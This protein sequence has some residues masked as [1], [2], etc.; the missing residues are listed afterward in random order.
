MDLT[1]REGGT[2][3]R[4]YCR[5]ATR[6]IG[7]K[8][9]KRGREEPYFY[10]GRSAETARGLKGLRVLSDPPT[11][12]RSKEVEHLLGWRASRLLKDGDYSREGEQ[13]PPCCR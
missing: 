12:K 7:E 10:G 6:R 11:R 4:N 9:R 13:A 8:R 3:V 1:S 5:G 2:A